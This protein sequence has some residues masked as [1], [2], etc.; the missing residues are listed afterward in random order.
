VG[1]SDPLI[2]VI[3]RNVDVTWL[4]R[5]IPQ[6]PPDSLVCLCYFVCVLVREYVCMRYVH[7]FPVG[8]S[9]FVITVRVWNESW[10][11]AM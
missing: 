11:A 6:I 10:Q 9:V 8:I 3:F 4:G 7:M 5:K 1:W 2:E